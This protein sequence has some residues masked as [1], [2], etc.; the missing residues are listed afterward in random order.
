M[1]KAQQAAEE[2]MTRVIRRR[3]TF[4]AGAECA[5]PETPDPAVIEA[6]AKGCFMAY[7]DRGWDEDD[8]DS[9]WLGE[10]VRDVWRDL[11]R[12]AYA[13]LRGAMQ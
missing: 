7:N 9:E 8:W 2:P 5:L 3:R 6:M 11:A 1:S 12:A 4:V 10:R 13:A